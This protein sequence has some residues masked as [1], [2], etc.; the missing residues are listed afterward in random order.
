MFGEEIIVCRTNDGPRIE[1]YHTIAPKRKT[2]KYLSPKSDHEAE[3]EARF[4]RGV[5]E[6]YW[7]L[8]K[9]EFS[10]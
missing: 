10:K 3:E 4:I 9:K 6:R 8:K 7:K 5:E 1:P 2:K